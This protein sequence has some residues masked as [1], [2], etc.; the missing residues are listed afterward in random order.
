M[1]DPADAEAAAPVKLEFQN[2]GTSGEG[3]L[4]GRIGKGSAPATQ[5]FKAPPPDN[6]FGATNDQQ[7]LLGG[8]GG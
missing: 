6:F 4:D 3:T 2:F 8:E 5:A 7:S 1:E